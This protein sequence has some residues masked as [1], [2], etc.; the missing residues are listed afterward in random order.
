MKKLFKYGL[1]ALTLYLLS[2]LLLFPA[3]RAYS[4]VR[5]R[6]KIPLALYQVSGSVWHG[7]IELLRTSV[8]DIDD[9]DWRVHLLPLLGGHLELG[10]T[11]AGSVNPVRVVVGRNL[12]G[13]LY[14]HDDGGGLPLTELEHLLSSQPLGLQ[15]TLELDLDDIQLDSGRLSKVNGTVTWDQAGLGDPVNIDVGDLV[16]TVSTRDKTIQALIKDRDGPLGVDGQFL[17]M[18][19]STYR[20]TATLMIKDKTRSDLQQSLRLLGTPNRDGRL[21]I[22]RRGRLNLDLR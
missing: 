16:A 12:D 15:G 14:V 6:F 21:M 19:D 2:L 20:L 13:S 7:H 18:P 10:L 4:L 11:L 3:D 8:A 22:S 17:L 1:F 9:I 5:D